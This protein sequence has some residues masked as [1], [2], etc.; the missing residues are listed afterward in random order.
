MR[1]RHIS[2]AVTISLL[3][4]SAHA[5]ADE[6]DWHFDLG[7]GARFGQIDGHA[8][9]PSG[10]E[11]GT[12]SQ[13]RPTFNELGIDN[14]TVI[15]VDAAVEWRREGL[16]LDLQFIRPSGSATL[17]TTLI[18]QGDTFPAGTPVNADIQ[19]D[20]YRLAY[21][22]RFGLLSRE[23]TLTPMVGGMLFSFDYSLKATD[24][25]GV[26]AHRS[27]SKASPVIGAT[28]EWRPGGGAV[29]FAFLGSYN[30]PV[31]D[32]I[33]RGYD[34]EARAYYDFL[35]DPDRKLAGYVGVGFEHLQYDD[36][37]KQTLPN[38]IDFDLGPLFTVGL[39][40]RY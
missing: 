24:G 31:A 18:S 28:L 27:Y 14:V 4:L 17:D 29:G 23:L 22:H 32:A 12:S 40:L 13:N 7:S 33:P 39:E 2:F 6:G 8:Q 19:L 10:G 3:A 20:E 1:R 16:Y 30:L 15:D 25:S 37:S 5:R 11:P 26:S 21:G 35:R 38:D 9:T 34:V 36:S